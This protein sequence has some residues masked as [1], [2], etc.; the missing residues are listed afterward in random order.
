MKNIIRGGKKAKLHFLQ[1]E[2]GKPLW[3]TLN[4]I[5]D[6]NN[7][8]F[9]WKSLLLCFSLVL[10]MTWGLLQAH[11]FFFGEKNSNHSTKYLL[12]TYTV[13]GARYIK[14]IKARYLP[15]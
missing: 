9:K 2:T 5:E 12:R 14:M 4:S 11:S 3:V 10:S 8:Y 1:I 13:V 15:S 6:R 7:Y